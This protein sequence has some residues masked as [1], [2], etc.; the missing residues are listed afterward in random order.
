MKNVRKHRTVAIFRP[1]LIAPSARGPIPFHIKCFRKSRDLVSPNLNL[2][3]DA[4]NNFAVSLF[5][6]GH[7]PKT[8]ELLEFFKFLFLLFTIWFISSF[9]IKLS[10]KNIAFPGNQTSTLLLHSQALYQLSYRNFNTN[11]WKIIYLT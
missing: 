8:K 1:F 4:M 10:G 11:C 9:K 2:Q 6:C 7:Q 3:L 5:V